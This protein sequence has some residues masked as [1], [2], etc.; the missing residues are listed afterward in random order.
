VLTNT[1]KV[2]HRNHVL[3]KQVLAWTDAREHQD[4]RRLQSACAQQHLAAR[5]QLL[6]HAATHKLDPGR[7]PPVSRILTTCAS[8][9]TCR[10][11]RLMWA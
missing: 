7:F 10:L 11:G 2:V 8:V 3:V 9:I 1:G 4:V 5:Q 6:G